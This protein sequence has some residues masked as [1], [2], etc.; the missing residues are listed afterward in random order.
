MEIRNWVTG[1]EV[2]AA[3]NVGPLN[4]AS[5]NRFSE[6]YWAGA[7]AKALPGQGWRLPETVSRREAQP[8]RAAL[9]AS[10]LRGYVDAWLETGRKPD[11]SECPK[12]RTLSYVAPSP[13]FAVEEYLEKYPTTFA[14]VLN[15][16]G[17][18]LQVAERRWPSG[19]AH[20]FFQA[21]AHSALRLFVGMF[22]SDWKERL[23]KCRYSKCGRYFLHPKPR[24]TYKKGIY[25]TPKCAKAA[26]AVAANLKRRDQG[27][28]RLIDA[29]AR[30]LLRRRIAGRTWQDDA[31]LKGRLAEKLSVVI[32]E[33]ELQGYRDEVKVNWVTR[34]RDAIERRRRQLSAFPHR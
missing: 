23:C 6:R 20:D 24:E 5:L 16:R 13:L 28:A 19:V 17:F 1:E 14:P 11:G 33:E 34:N 4:E 12:K 21:Q 2:I 10:H 30:L 27:K 15:A 32:G 31:D 9:T 3:L 7:E 22:A 25:C 18:T 29:A 8:I 26:A